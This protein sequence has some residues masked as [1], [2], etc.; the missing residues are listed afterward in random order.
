MYHENIRIRNHHSEYSNT[1]YWWVWVRGICIRQPRVT[2]ETGSH[3]E[4]TVTESTIRILT[5]VMHT[6]IHTHLHVW[7][8]PKGVHTDIVCGDLLAAHHTM[9]TLNSR[10]PTVSAPEVLTHIEWQNTTHVI[11]AVSVSMVLLCCE[12]VFQHNLSVVG[13]TH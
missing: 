6:D 13:T 11:T 1:N 10:N 12:K 5:R 4:E 7:Q 9:M 8:Y 3:T 2:V